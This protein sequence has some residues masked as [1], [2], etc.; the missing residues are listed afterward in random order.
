MS[1]SE[2]LLRGRVA[3]WQRGRAAAN[4]TLSYFDRGSMVVWPQTLLFLEKIKAKF[5]F[6]RNVIAS[7]SVPGIY[8]R[9]RNCKVHKRN[10]KGKCNVPL[11]YG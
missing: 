11:F 3:A 7:F 1:I 9:L 8:C 6:L 5:R 2:F 4:K 10:N